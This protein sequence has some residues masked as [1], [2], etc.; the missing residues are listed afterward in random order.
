MNSP[1]P[2][3]RRRPWL[4]YAGFTLLA[5]LVTYG[6]WPKPT[7]VEIATVNRGPLRS[8]INEEGK[9][10]IRER[11]LVSAPVA[12]NLRRIP[13]KVGSPIAQAGEVVAVIDPLTPAP[14]DARSRSLSEARRDSASAQLDRAREAHR[15]AASELKRSEKLHEARALSIQDLEQAQWR[16]VSASRELTAAE[17]ALRLAEAE[18]AEFHAPGKAE[19]AHVEV[20]APARG[21]VLRMIEESARVVPAGAPLLEIGDPADLEVIVEVLSRDGAMISPGTS[22]ELEQWGGQDSLKAI[23]RLVEPAAFTKVSA[24]GVEE[25]RVYVV[26]DLLTPP[27]QRGNLGD[28]FRVE[29]RII[30]WQTNQTVKVAGGALFRQGD[31][32]SAFVLEGHVARLRSVQPGRNSGTEVQ[33][34]DG[35]REGEQ[36]ILYPG[37]RIKPG[38]RVAPVKI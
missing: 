1:D 4:P 9:T 8:T 11:F 34:L 30:A 26:A 24:L 18:L 5:V 15:F 6:L 29:A 38:A 21:R 27:N 13:L 20:R 3:V 2:K 28:Q 19:G 23:V 32:W 7:P 16:E 12:G 37:D 25:Q 35:L 14:L 10:R 36:V 33:I 31:Q 22:V 17:S